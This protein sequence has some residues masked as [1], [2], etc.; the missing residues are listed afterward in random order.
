MS[1][2]HTAIPYPGVTDPLITTARTGQLDGG[3][4]DIPY[5]GVTGPLITTARTDQLECVRSPYYDSQDG[6]AG[7]VSTLIFHPSLRSHDPSLFRIFFE[8]RW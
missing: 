6:S 7:R 3:H 1:G 8:L 4:T 2:D 5:S